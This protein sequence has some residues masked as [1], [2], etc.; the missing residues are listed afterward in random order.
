MKNFTKYLDGNGKSCTFALA[1]EERTVPRP[2]GELR[3][4]SEEGQRKKSEKVLVERKIV[5]TFAKLSA[6]KNRR[7]GLKRTLKY[8]Q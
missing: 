1:F 3:G 8:L 7:L 4:A 2:R 6:A 5:L